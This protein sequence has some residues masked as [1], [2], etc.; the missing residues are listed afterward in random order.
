MAGVSCEVLWRG[1]NGDGEQKIR[2]MSEAKKKK[3]ERKI[4]RSVK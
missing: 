1:R 4:F 2:R 3:K